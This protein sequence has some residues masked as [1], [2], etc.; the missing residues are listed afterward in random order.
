[1]YI[2][3]QR[4]LAVGVSAETMSIGT[5]WYQ[6]LPPLYRGGFFACTKKEMNK[7]SSLKYCIF[8][9]S[10]PVSALTKSTTSFIVESSVV[11]FSANFLE[12]S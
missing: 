12:S 9:P 2:R 4:A 10:I 6:Y 11:A 3:T 5:N 7:C 1:M 8:Y